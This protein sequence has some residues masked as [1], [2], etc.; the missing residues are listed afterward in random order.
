[1]PKQYAVLAT[2]G[3]YPGRADDL[4]GCTNDGPDTADYIWNSLHWVPGRTTIL[5]NADAK[6][7][8][9]V[10]CLGT[11]L[12]GAVDGDELLF[13]FSG[14]GSQVPDINGDESDHLDEILCPYDYDRI[15]DDP[16]S[17][18]VLRDLFRLKHP[19]AFLTV[20][21]D[22]CHSATVTRDLF[23]KW[24]YLAPPPELEARCNVD[25]PRNRMGVKQC[26]Y[27]ETAYDQNHL[28]LA[29][30]RASQTAADAHFQGRANGAWTYHLLRAA[31]KLEP[32]SLAHDV[33]MAAFLGIKSGGFS[34]R[35]TIE[36][37]KALQER[38][39]LGGPVK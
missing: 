13:Y 33:F 8:Y 34:Q 35:P 19:G 32:G 5:R 16:L 29:A 27:R 25:L 31:K 24:R 37:V 39:F 22:S 17:D 6:K 12:S 11:M 20:I 38:P 30:C 28:L 4:A 9:I 3:D 23:R 15:W 26:K 18:D 10:D 2:I 1:M 14:H 36:G 21:I 7:K